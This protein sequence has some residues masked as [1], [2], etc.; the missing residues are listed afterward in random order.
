MASFCPPRIE[1]S[2]RFGLER[3]YLACW[4]FWACWARERIAPC[5]PS[6]RSG[7]RPDEKTGLAGSS[8]ARAVRLPT[9]W[10]IPPWA[11]GRAK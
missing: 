5:R 9:N 11:Q 7:Q 1:R 8:I 4:A 6:N 3:T 2:Q 10:P